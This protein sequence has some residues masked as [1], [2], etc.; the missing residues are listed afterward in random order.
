MN[1]RWTYS[2][3]RGKLKKGPWT[4]EEDLHLLRYIKLHGEGRW[5][6]LAK[7]AGLQRCGKSCRLRWV[8]YL[9]P[10]LKLGNITPEE[11]RVIIELH[12]L[13]G[14]RWSLIA[15]RIPG[16]TDNEI[17]NYW[18]SHL[19]KKLQSA[20]NYKRNDCT[21]LSLPIQSLE[22]PN[23]QHQTQLQ[24]LPV[25]ST[26]TSSASAATEDRP[27]KAI[28]LQSPPPSSNISQGLTV[29]NRSIGNL[30]SDQDLRME[31]ING[32]QQKP[33]SITSFA[34]AH[35]L[36]QNSIQNQ[37]AGID[38]RI[39]ES[40]AMPSILYQLYSSAQDD[41]TA[42]QAFTASNSD[43]TVIPPDGFESDS[44]FDFGSDI[45]LWNMCPIDPATHYGLQQ[46]P[47]ASTSLNANDR[48]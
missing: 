32:A 40:D 36:N 25:N 15:E 23:P 38:P 33:L 48:Q 28:N 24:V 2:A 4:F 1:S 3:E 16:R 44:C 7:A 30:T 41:A 42:L 12:A 21:P 22:H 43:V 11:E 8:N 5:S 18:R 29:T 6:A 31:Y 45:L 35:D 9:R 37:L 10:D 47:F 46:P 27:G 13:W 14:N 17:K 20:A 39:L 26:A 34:T 19:K